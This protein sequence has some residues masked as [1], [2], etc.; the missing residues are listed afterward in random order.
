MNGNSFTQVD[1][2]LAARTRQ[3]LGEA[4]AMAARPRRSGHAARPRSR[5]RL[6]LTAAA[7][8]VPLLLT[9]TGAVAAATG[10]W[11]NFRFRFVQEPAAAPGHIYPVEPLS[12]GC[13]P[14]MAESLAGTTI[15]DAR[16]ALPYPV[17]AH[18][19]LAPTAVQLSTCAFGRP[20]KPGDFG[21]GLPPGQEA[22]RITY[23][24]AGTT[25]AIVEVASP[26][27]GQAD[28]TVDRQSPIEREEI[29]GR[30]TLVQY[31]STERRRVAGAVF[32][33]GG[34]TVSLVFLGPVDHAT[35]VAFLSHLA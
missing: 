4:E 29:A 18:D 5:R 27:Q 31:T 33:T 6:A 1:L 22:L 21:F 30:E 7:L 20:G 12:R 32:L 15:G 14:G 16:A 17:L 34:T 11:K 24:T 2:Q 8:A 23:R 10:Q 19:R 9:T 13:P 28:M 3:A 25:V 35:A 26:P